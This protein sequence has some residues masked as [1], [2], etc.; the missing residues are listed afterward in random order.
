MIQLRFLLLLLLFFSL[1]SINLNAKP[2]AKPQFSKISYSDQ[3]LANKA[4][5]S[6]HHA[7][8]EVNHKEQYLI[9]ILT[10]KEK[11]LLS[12][13]GFAIA[14][15]SQWQTEFEHKVSQSKTSITSKTENTSSLQAI[16][17]FECYPTVEE[18]YQQAQTLAN[19]YP[20]LASWFDIGDSWMKVNQSIGYDLMVLKITNSEIPNEKPILFIH[21]S[22]HARE[23]APAALTLDFA[24]W[25]LNNY[26][27]DAE[28]QWLVNNREIH[29]LFHMNPDG[30]KIAE[31]QILQRKNTNQNHCAGTTVGVDLNRNFSHSWN[32]TVDGSSGDE[33]AE[34]YRGIA[35]ES[36]PE[37]Q[38]VS[39]YIRSLFPDSRG[40]LDSDAAPQDTSG[41]HLDIHSYGKLILW[42]FGH[43]AEPS[44]NDNGFIHLGNKLAWFNQYTPKQAIGLYPTDGTSDDVSYGELGVAALTFE[45]G[46]SFF[47]GC[48]QY[49]S[50][51]KP[52]NLLA[53]AY[54][55]KVSKAPYLLS[56]GIDVSVLKVNQSLGQTTVTAATPVDLEIGA[57]LKQSTLT[58][59]SK[60]LASFEYVIDGS[61]ES[62]NDITV[63]TQSLAFDE[64]GAATSLSQIDTS[65]LTPGQ[66]LLSVRAKDDQ[67]QYGVPSSVFINISDNN[68]PVPSFTTSCQNLTCSFD[69]SQSQDSD[70]EI[71][72]YQWGVY[73]GNNVLE[74]IGTEQQLTYDFANAG[75]ITILLTTEDNNGLTAQTEKTIT[76]TAIEVITITPQKTSKGG[77]NIHWLMLY[78]LMVIF[79][80]RLTFIAKV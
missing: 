51:I 69:A 29:L 68:A 6:L 25:L 19:Q 46:S 42:P 48:G 50:Q 18:T 61:F 4:L 32:S 37:T 70:G 34:D 38:A 1:V 75:D 80:Q 23:Y 21:S 45:L 44:E 10:E 49:N 35:P 53:F 59:S 3:K 56:L 26:Q 73:L 40:P 8:L 36:E 11:T 14:P 52:D 13:Y 58:Q 66:H 65:G 67:G 57:T 30:R 78:F 20:N 54:A 27:T 55:A 74:N 77:G 79:L 62:S 64:A 15:A 39:N 60:Q 76:L 24:H 16:E 72:S 33:C 17:G 31:Q 2:L 28:A 7:I 5:I 12:Q 41:L 71:V 47:E 22:M 9:A 63:L 43:K